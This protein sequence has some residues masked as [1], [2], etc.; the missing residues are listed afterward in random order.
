VRGRIRAD[1]RVERLGYTTRTKPIRAT[2]TGGTTTTADA[3]EEWTQLRVLAF[4]VLLEIA[5]GRSG[6][7]LTNA[8]SV[9]ATRHVRNRSGS[10]PREV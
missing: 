2:T 4:G 1:E 9:W 5:K 6:F 10:W 8:W 3:A 7:E